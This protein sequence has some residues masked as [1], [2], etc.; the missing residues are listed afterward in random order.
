[1][2]G[3]GGRAREQN[4]ETEVFQIPATFLERVRLTPTILP[5]SVPIDYFVDDIIHWY[6]RNESEEVRNFAGNLQ[7]KR[8]VRNELIF[9]I[10]KLNNITWRIPIMWNSIRIPTNLS[11]FRSAFPRYRILRYEND[12]LRIDPRIGVLDMLEFDEGLEEVV[13]TREEGGISLSDLSDNGRQQINNA[14]DTLRIYTARSLND[15]MVSDALQVF[16]NEFIFRECGTPREIINRWTILDLNWAL[17]EEWRREPYFRDRRR[18]DMYLF[19]NRTPEQIEAHRDGLVFGF[20]LRRDII[21]TSRFGRRENVEPENHEGVDFRARDGID[22]VIAS[23]RGRVDRAYLENVPRNI[24]GG[25]HSH[26]RI[27]HANGWQTRY[28]HMDSFD[29]RIVVGAQ[30][31]KGQQLGKS[32]R[33][34]NSIPHLHFEIRRNETTPMD[35]EL[36]FHGMEFSHSL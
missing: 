6:L 2:S 8:R 13:R 21:I 22:V 9:A 20:P 33:R 24:S 34:L 32:G 3:R 23:E 35:P 1:M 11:F 15:P 26:L 10:E 31:N 36:F 28:L 30:V 19:E 17:R 14:L 16:Q 4:Y 25:G 29:E 7:N 18:P 12:P 5:K 27:I